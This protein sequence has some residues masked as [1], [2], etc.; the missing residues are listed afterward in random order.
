MRCVYHISRELSRKGH[1]VTV[2]TTNAFDFMTDFK[3]SG[4]EYSLDSIHVRYFRNVTRL[5]GLY[6]SPDMIHAL[7]K[8]VQN[9]DII[10]MHEY[11]TF[12][13]VITHFYAQKYRRPYVITAHGS[14]PLVVERILLK[15]L[16]DDAFGDRILRDA[17]KLLASSK[18]EMK[19]Y[20][21]MGVPSNKIVIV[22]NGIKVEL[23]ETLPKPGTFKKEFKLDYDSAMIV[24]IGRV[25]KRKGLG[26]LLDAF[27][28]LKD[29][30][31]V[32]VI[33][34]PDEGYMSVLKEKASRLRITE[35]VIFTGFISERDK[36][37]A[38]VDSEVVVYPGM[39]ESFPLVPLEAAL[40]SKPVIVSDDSVMGEIVTHGGFGFSIRYGDV[41]Q[42]RDCL[43]TIL[44]DLTIAG[45]MG[46]KGRDFVKKN[47]NWRDI[48]SKLEHVYFDALAS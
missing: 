13:N 10:H 43:L 12:Q 9:S 32:L 48:V 23:F 5:G 20:F 44:N 45:E 11:R 36:L 41:A 14:I 1:E 33:A 16:F 38:Y 22:P 26:F 34:G 29:T 25:H 31:A 47:Y 28:R 17:C 27:A 46:R 24:Y 19:Q 37:A 40:C 3:V 30:N 21:H 8:G 6:L 7:K 2:Y 15:K 42:L 39:H 18:I 4:H 35:K